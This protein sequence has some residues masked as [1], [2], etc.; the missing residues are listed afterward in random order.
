MLLE[1]FTWLPNVGADAHIGPQN[2]GVYVVIG[3]YIRYDKEIT[4]Y[5][6]DNGIL[7]QVC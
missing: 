6:Y 3:P 1:R 4:Y 2:N 5:G 7:P